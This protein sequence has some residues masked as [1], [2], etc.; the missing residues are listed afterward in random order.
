MPLAANRYQTAFDVLGVARDAT[1]EDVRQAYALVRAAHGADENNVPPRIRDAFALLGDERAANSYR[2][3]LRACADERRLDVK[4]EHLRAFLAMCRHWQV[5]TWED[6]EF[7]GAYIVWEAD[8]PEP[9]E[10][11]RQRAAAQ[12]PAESP[13]SIEQLLRER[14]NRRLFRQLLVFGVL[15]A[16]A[17]GLYVG[18][19]VYLK[20]RRIAAIQADTVSANQIL[21]KTQEDAGHLARRFQEVTG[22]DY[23][24]TEPATPRSPELDRA[25]IQHESVRR[26][27][28]EILAGRETAAGLERLRAECD[29]LSSLLQ[30]QSASGADVEAAQR[31]RA[32]TQHASASI[33]ADLTNLSHIQQMLEADRL[34]NALNNTERT[35]P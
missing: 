7:P 29:R 4:P 35:P 28:D 23:L 26:A 20:Q 1:T 2:E 24:M 19:P 31:M 21:T 5:F 6:R 22:L 3:V 34:E 16:A 27:W 9:E 13:G 18:V 8:H 11:S 12:R 10:V 30:G 25:L 15:S 32:D 14:R 17:Y 33:D